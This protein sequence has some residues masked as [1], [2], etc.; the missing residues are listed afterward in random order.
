MNSHSWRR[1]G[2]TTGVSAPLRQAST[3][4]RLALAG[5]YAA[6]TSTLVS[7]TTRVADDI[8]TPSQPERALSRRPWIPASRPGQ[9][10]DVFDLFGLQVEV[11]DFEILAHV[12][13]VGGAG[14]GHHADVE[15]EAED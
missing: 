2:L 14:Q 15:G 1:A 5:L 13:G 10:F 3:T 8:S 11:E 6:A 12:G 9:P 4:R 7:S